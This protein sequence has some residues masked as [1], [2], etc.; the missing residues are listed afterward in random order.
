MHEGSLPGRQASCSSHSHAL[1]SLN[2]R[3]RRAC[4]TVS[5]SLELPL[6]AAA[7]ARAQVVL[8]AAGCQRCLPGCTVWGLGRLASSLLCTHMSSHQVSNFCHVGDVC[9]ADIMH[10]SHHGTRDTCALQPHTTSHPAA[11]CVMYTMYATTLSPVC[12]TACLCC[13]PYLALALGTQRHAS[14]PPSTRSRHHC[15]LHITLLT[16]W[17]TLCVDASLGTCIALCTFVS[18]TF[19]L[20]QH[21]TA[22]M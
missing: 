9:D 7:K 15:L 21:C 19:S 6:A 3:Q 14:R 12:L 22:S 8:R 2:Q 4:T 17:C 1:C 11:S 16:T 18:V 10:H 20:L 5:T 13:L